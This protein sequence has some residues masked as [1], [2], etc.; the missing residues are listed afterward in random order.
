MNQLPT[1]AISEMK[2]QSKILSTFEEQYLEF[3]HSHVHESESDLLFDPAIEMP[4]EELLRLRREKVYAG[5]KKDCKLLIARLKS[6]LE[7]IQS[8]KN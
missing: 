4:D 8:N 3:F 6:H 7:L 5:M 2:K 1:L